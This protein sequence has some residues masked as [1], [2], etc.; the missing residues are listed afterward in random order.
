MIRRDRLGFANEAKLARER[1]VE[2]MEAPVCIDVVHDERAPRPQFHPSPI[3]LEAD[4]AL[5]VQ[6]VVDEQ[7]NLFKFRE[8]LWESPST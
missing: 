5:A 6:A 2:G 1:F 3:Q 8:Q 7:I 4:I